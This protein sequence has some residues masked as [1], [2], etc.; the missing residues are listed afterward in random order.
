MSTEQLVD[1]LV[2]PDSDGEPMADNTLQF[3]WILLIYA[4]IER[5]FIADRNVF[6]ASNL[7][8]YL[9]K[10]NVALRLAPDVMVAFG[11][12]KGHRGSWRPWDEDNVAPQVVFEVLSPGNRAGELARK[13]QLYEQY[14]VEEYYIL[15]PDRQTLQVFLL[16]DGQLREVDQVDGWVSP[17]LTVR[18][19]F[20]DEKWVLRGPGG[21]PFQTVDHIYDELLE[22]EENRRRAQAEA[23][24]RLRQL[25][26]QSRRVREEQGR[27]NEEQRRADEEQ[28]RA[29]EEQRRADAERRR[30]EEASQQAARLAE[31]LRELGVDPNSL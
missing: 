22:A 6:V 26:E 10:G 7:L 2:Y 30:A 27:A 23:E 24:I 1:E 5:L 31:K 19:S 9:E 29:D 11:R 20:E 25:E 17:R 21:K 18:F 16:Q 28:R 14:G 3:E 15:D 13:F 4:G 8:W 12:P